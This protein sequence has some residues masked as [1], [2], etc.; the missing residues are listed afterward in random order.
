[1]ALVIKL[2]N[3]CQVS[4]ISNC[5]EN[6]FF[7]KPFLLLLMHFPVSHLR[8][9]YLRF[10]HS[11]F[12]SEFRGWTLSPLLLVAISALNDT[13]S[14]GVLRKNV[15]HTLG[16]IFRCWQLFFQ[17]YSTTVVSL[18]L[19]VVVHFELIAQIPL[20]HRWKDAWHSLVMPLWL[21]KKQ[22]RR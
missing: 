11:N 18:N 15:Q 16:R 13:F 6:R 1:M 14:V 10:N 4:Y 3:R 17:E 7:P 19:V 9:V 2:I 8:L 5:A 12:T 22:P 20:R 21:W